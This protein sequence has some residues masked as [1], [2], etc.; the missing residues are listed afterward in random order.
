MTRTGRYKVRW[1]PDSVY[2][3]IIRQIRRQ[4]NNAFFNIFSDGTNDQLL[5]FVADDT[6]IRCK[7]NV[8][9]T[10]HHMVCADILMPGQ[11]MFSVLAGYL[12][13][14]IKIGRPW[15][16]HWFNFPKTNGFIEVNAEGDFLSKGKQSDE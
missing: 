1:V 5:T 7:E 15:S 16:P 13:D 12:C 6:A 14:G 11:S 3:N 4:Y 8:L 9:R 2:L 10:F